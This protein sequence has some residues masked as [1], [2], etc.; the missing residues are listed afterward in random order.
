M[1]SS[2]SSVW[3]S[4]RTFVTFK[5]KAVPASLPYP[6]LLCSCYESSLLRCLRRSSTYRLLVPSDLVSATQRRLARGPI[7]D[8]G[9]VCSGVHLFCSQSLHFWGH[10]PSS[11]STSLAMAA[12]FSPPVVS[13]LRGKLPIISSGHPLI[14]DSWHP[15]GDSFSAMED[16]RRF[17]NFCFPYTWFCLVPSLL[18]R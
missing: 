5:R 9:S 11:R 15:C 16:I 6:I 3:A 1:P 2:N 4:H 18:Y 10:L 7:D 8:M 13:F 12:V 17:E 14:M